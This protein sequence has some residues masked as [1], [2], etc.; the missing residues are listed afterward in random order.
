[1]YA[2]ANK[3]WMIKEQ[4]P[5]EAEEMEEIEVDINLGSSTKII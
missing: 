3:H 5:I 2:V 4:F 1:M